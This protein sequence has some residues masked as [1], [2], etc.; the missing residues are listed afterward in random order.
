MPGKSKQSN[1]RKRQARHIE[2]SEEKRGVPPKRAKQIGYATVNKQQNGRT[3]SK[4][5]RTSSS[6][7]S[8]KKR[9]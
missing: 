8:R 9:S 4:R 6:S 5:S 7:R 1:V 2:E 3:S